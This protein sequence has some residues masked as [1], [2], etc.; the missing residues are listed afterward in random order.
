LSE[1]DPGAVSL[2]GRLLRVTL[3]A[4][5]GALSFTLDPVET[6]VPAGQSPDVTIFM[7]GQYGDDLPFAL[8]DAGG[9]EVYF[10]FCH[11]AL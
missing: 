6:I 2:R 10:C 11:A 1:G 7:A 8:A 4:Q 5:P 3:R 9:S